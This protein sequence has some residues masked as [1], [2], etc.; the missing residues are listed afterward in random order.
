MKFTVTRQQVVKAL[1]TEPLMSGSWIHINRDDNGVAI[2]D[3]AKYKNKT[4]CAVCAV[5]SILDCR[6]GNKMG[7]E[8]LARLGSNIV[9]APTKDERYEILEDDQIPDSG[10][11]I[12]LKYLKALAKAAMKNKLP[13]SALSILFEGLMDLD[14]SKYQT[15]EGLANRKAREILINFVKSNF[16]TKLVIDTKREKGY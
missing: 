12:D 1:K 4:G 15:Q 8:Q 13:M 16:P 6:L 7:L 2:K 10:G 14:Y 9:E 11:E 3:K 5:G